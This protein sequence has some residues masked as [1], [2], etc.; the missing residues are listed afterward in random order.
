MSI[1][2]FH[3][4]LRIAM[5][6]LIGIE[7]ALFVFAPF[8]AAGVWAVQ[9]H[10]LPQAGIMPTALLF[11]V[12]TLFTMF[13]VGLYTT[14]QRSGRA[15]L[16]VRIVVA[17][18]AAVALCAL[19]FYLVPEMQFDR[20]T[21]GLTG[22]LA[23]SL[24]GVTRLLF[25]RMVD[26]DIFKSRVV[27][28]GAGKLASS[29]VA[30][31]R[32]S[33]QRGFRLVG[34][35]ATPGDQPV[36]PSDRL[37]PAPQNLYQ[38]AEAN[39]IDEIV[40]AMDDRRQGFPLHEFLECRLAGI[41][42]LELA[43]F[44]ERETGKV[45]LEILNPSW[46]IFGDGFRVSQLQSALER[47]FDVV[48][49]LALLLLALPFMLATALAIILEEGW[50]APILYRQQRVGQHGRTFDVIKFRSMGVDSEKSGVAQWAVANDPRVTRVGALIRKVRIDELPQL[51]N[52][53]RGDMSFVGPRPERPEFVTVLEDKIPYYRE[54]HTVKPGI[55]G[56]AQLC[57]PYGSSE[58]DAIEKLQ[59]DLYYV[60]NRS[61]LLDLA[62]L[63]QT[64]EVVLWGKGAR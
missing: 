38:W 51:W 5:L 9:P 11:A 26:Q 41:Q 1:R 12:Y 31:R 19:T 24:S 29:L 49:S 10:D 30:L 18:S 40:V 63:V 42:V 4:H 45:H 58:K 36:V 37:I 64:V 59:Y 15:G 8:L 53:L 55:T 56:W 14:R 27:V 39:D 35:M 43:T 33:D 61:L 52:V 22:V 54:R 13:A 60:K 47:S 2:L 20:R 48:V 3:F 21:L 57:Y 17:V 16:T 34:F 25:E 50:G 46:I 23:I 6:L 28:Y 44:L 62:I 32:R 7:G